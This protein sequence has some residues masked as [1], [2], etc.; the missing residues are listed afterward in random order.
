MAALR[1]RDE[2]NKVGYLQKPKGSD[3]YHQILDFLGASHIRYALTHDPIIFDS[4]VKQFWSTATL[5]SPELGPPVILATID[6]TSYTIT[7]ESLRSQLQLVDD[8]GIDDLPIV[9]IYSG[10]DNLGSILWGKLCHFWLLCFPKL[11]KVKEQGMMYKLSHHLFVPPPIP[12]PIPEPMPEPD[13]PQDHLSTTPRQ[14]TSDPIAPIFEHGQSL[15]P[16]IASFSRVHKT[17]DDPLSTFHHGKINERLF[18]S[19]P[20]KVH[21]APPA[22]YTSGGARTLLS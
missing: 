7:E 5:R 22:I 14:Q 18:P 9:E 19:I 20:T 13:Q 6:K 4:L 21:S 2:H 12:E 1:Y 15:D 10:M 11:K 8:G 17:D 16:N 3:D